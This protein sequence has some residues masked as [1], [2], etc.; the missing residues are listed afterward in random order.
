MHIIEK[1]VNHKYKMQKEALIVLDTTSNINNLVNDPLSYWIDSTP[2]TNF[3]S[4]NEDINVDTVIVGGGMVGITA[5]YL[6]KKEGLK[7]AILEADK[8][9]MNTTGHT[10][11]K[12]TSQH[13][14][15]YN[16]LK[17]QFG[18]EKAKQYADANEYAI[19]FIHD[20][21]KDEN[22]NCDFS[23]Q[24]SYV[25]TQTTEYTNV[26]QSEVEVA[27]KL[28]IKAFYQEEIPLPFKIKAAVRFDNQAQ[29]HPRKYLLHL[30]NKIQGDGCYIFEGT[31]AVDVDEGAKVKIKT[32]KGFTVTADRLI[33]ASHFPFY[34]G[35]GLYFTRI[36][37]HRSYA[38]G[39]RIKEK[40]PSG[41]FI[42]A[43]EPSR[44]LRSQPY[45]DGELIIIGG[46]HHKTGH[47]ENLL[48]HYKI[49]KEF[50]EDN[51]NVIDIPYRW[52]AEDYNTMDGAPYVGHLTSRTP[53]IYV[54]TG[55][56]K[57]G[58]T[59]STVSAIM[60]RDLIVKGENPWTEV[61]NP[62]RFTPSASA[63][64]F[65]TQNLNVAK[66]LFEGK[67]QALPEDLDIKNGEAQVIRIDGHRVGAYRDEEGSLHIIDTTCTHLGCELN[68]NSAEKSWDC[69]CHGSRFTYT[70]DIM[71]GPALNPLNYYNKGKNKIDPNIF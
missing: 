19:K 71:E 2:T 18:E 7:V 12:I 16:K 35:L 46:E 33:V 23:F 13:G 17:L 50:A 44:S 11:A 21:V 58:M 34:D 47:G 1:V 64:T 20:L 38:I 10:T 67:L 28:G 29:F 25:Y 37:P 32:H 42:N 66:E 3:P 69:P 51:Y 54:A 4:L 40:F 30:A 15:I 49:L 57:W 41:M 31:R 62:S 6:L 26:I 56:G 45:K 43:E 60:I 48:E 70:G 36:Y 14:L 27:S 9:L 61:Y 55:F 5:A 22:I 63:K 68:W 53:N 52:S 65:V 59:N 8:I 24:P 39:T